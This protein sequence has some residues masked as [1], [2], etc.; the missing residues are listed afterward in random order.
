MEKNFKERKE[1]LVRWC[2]AQK[3][4]Y[5]QRQQQLEA[6]EAMIDVL[7]KAGD[8][9]EI[10]DSH[11]AEVAKAAAELESKRTQLAEIEKALYGKR[12]ELSQLGRDIDKQAKQLAALDG[13]LVD[14]HATIEQ[15][16][17]AREVLAQLQG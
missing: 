12:S 15:A 13:K 1:V 17:R 3:N 5:Q 16:Q 8:A 7:G 14:A 4:E 6:V 9:Q 11:R 2:N 10:V